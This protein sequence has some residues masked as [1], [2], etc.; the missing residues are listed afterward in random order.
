VQT[1]RFC[2]HLCKAGV[3][4]LDFRIFLPFLINW[5]MVG[6]D[7][8]PLSFSIHPPNLRKSIQPQTFSLLA[9]TFNE[10]VNQ[11]KFSR[12]LFFKKCQAFSFN[13]LKQTPTPTLRLHQILT[14]CF[15]LI[16]NQ[17]TS[18]MG[19]VSTHEVNKPC[20]FKLHLAGS[21]SKSARLLVY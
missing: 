15:C 14:P 12:Y 3:E 13:N 2:G 11:I 10:K 20:Y 4:G 7:S 6:K 17:T 21:F 19:G 1:P 9:C 16:L 5:F 18:V 8:S